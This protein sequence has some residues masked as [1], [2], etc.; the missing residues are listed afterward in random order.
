MMTAMM[1]ALNF[2]TMATVIAAITCAFVDPGSEIGSRHLFV[3]NVIDGVSCE[4]GDTTI[5]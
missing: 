1:A 2:V 3:D 5:K 4:G